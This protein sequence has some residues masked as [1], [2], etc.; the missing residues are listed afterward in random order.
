MEVRLHDPRLLTSFLLCGAKLGVVDNP[1]Q[2]RASCVVCLDLGLGYGRGSGTIMGMDCK[3]GNTLLMDLW[4]DPEGAC[5]CLKRENLGLFFS[6]S[7]IL[8]TSRQLDNKPSCFPSKNFKVF[9]TFLL[10]F[11][12]S[13]DVRQLYDGPSCLTSKNF[14]QLGTFLLSFHGSFDKPS[15]RRQTILSPIEKL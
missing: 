11:Q 15:I 13:F 10:I 2:H 3:M 4:E 7:T 8:L 12:D 5:G 1:V 14:R 6:A 9:G